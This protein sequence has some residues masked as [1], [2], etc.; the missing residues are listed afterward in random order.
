MQIIQSKGNTSK[1]SLSFTN[2]IIKVKTTE[3]FFIVAVQ[4]LGLDPKGY[5]PS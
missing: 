2:Y 1:F 4:N 3:I 5:F